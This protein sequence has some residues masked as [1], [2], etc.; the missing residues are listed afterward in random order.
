MSTDL[1][2]LR[3]L[4]A[5]EEQ[6]EGTRRLVND[7]R[8]LRVIRPRGGR[9]PESEAWLRRLYRNDRIVQ[10]KKPGVFDHLRSVGPWFVSVDGMPLSVLDGMTQTATLVGGFADDA[11]V[12]AFVEGAFAK[13]LLW[14]D[15]PSVA[16]SQT[17]TDFAALLERLVPGVGK[18]TFVNSGAEACEKAL[19]LCHAAAPTRRKVL[20]FEGS[21]HG[22]TLLALHASYNPAKRGPFEFAGYEVRFSRFP[23]WWQPNQPEPDVAEG[24]LDR[25][26]ER[27]FDKARELVGDDPLAREELDVLARVDEE[28][29][30]GAYFAVML[31][32]M[33]SEG[34]DRYA[35]SRFHRALRVLTRAHGV[36]LIYDEVQTGFGLGGTFA[37]H[38][39]F[40]LSTPDGEPDYPDCVTF[41]KRA[42]V[43]VVLSRYSDDEPTSSHPASLLRGRIHAERMV[44]DKKVA[45]VERWVGAELCAVA[46]EFPALVHH[47]RNRG[48]AVAF[49][50]PDNATLLRYLKQRFWRGAVVFGAGDRTVRYRLAT[51]WNRP[52]V[53]RL[54]QTVRESLR[55]LEDHPEEDPPTWQDTHDRRE[56]A[57]VPGLIRVRR[58]DAN[59]KEALLDAIIELEARVYEPARRDSREWLAKAFEPGGVVVVAELVHKSEFRVV[60]SALAAP[61]TS[62]QG[63]Q[64]G[65]EDPLRS[66]DT[67]LYSLAVTVDPAH[68]GH[69]LG[70]RLKQEQIRAAAEVRSPSGKAYE[71]VCGRNRIGKAATM[72]RLNVSL[73]LHEV[74]R[75]EKAYADGGEAL[76]YRL[77]VGPVRS[78]EASEA[79]RVD[80]QS[81]ISRPFAT[82]PLSLRRANETGQLYG[83]AV[84]KITLCN[85]VTPAIVRAVEYVAALSPDHPHMYLTS[86]RDEL[87]DKAVRTLRYH[88]EGT[89]IVVTPTGAYFGH[90]TAGARSASDPSVHRQGPRYF[91]GWRTVADVSELEAVVAECGAENVVGFFY[92]PLQERTGSTAWAD[93]SE[94]LGEFRRRSGIPVVAFET[95]SGGYRSGEGPFAGSSQSFVPDIRAWWGGGQIGFLH[96][97]PEFFVKKPLTM[98][99][100]WD[101]DELSLVR[102]HHQLRASL[103]LDVATRAKELATHLERFAEV[104]GLG[105]AGGRGLYRTLSGLGENF[106][107]A[108]AAD[109]YPLRTF[110]NGTTAVIP[111]IDVSSEE[112]SSFGAALDG[113]A[114]RVKE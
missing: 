32:P 74:S 28:L 64:G 2:K 40:G 92:E 62:L 9:L 101:G 31:E 50:L 6:Q 104:A 47:P 44:D 58:A 78:P 79:R 114:A 7:P 19:A 45:E 77:P 90:T 95:A 18:A 73:G 91:D 100:T 110:A 46:E 37:W 93:A 56:A 21:F 5:S 113:Q 69:G 54:F 68:H 75:H 35:T 17:A 52:E 66:T 80:F 67:L 108:L 97:G 24:F 112:L 12:R 13:D 98:V 8:P 103:R 51:G 36:S 39:R 43:G 61:L 84:N 65:D 105:T 49:D 53:E 106:L 57:T 59:E 94:A 27:A 33:Q 23:V 30:S 41:A 111:P 99:S 86:S 88:R 55:W 87:F 22:R 85:Y 63:I 10:E 42:Q 72:T 71:F 60:G 4:H 89:Q 70:R 15:D 82:P 3:D 38:Q 109:G 26:Q 48:Y 81:G 96:V 14:A 16:E 25:V 102:V 83:P 1:Q 76:Y 34:G 11:V 107:R 29:A 20:A